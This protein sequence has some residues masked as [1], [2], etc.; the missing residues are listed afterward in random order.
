M[1]EY[2]IS[3]TVLRMRLGKCLDLVEE[4]NVIVIIRRGNVIGRILP[5]SKYLERKMAELSKK[6]LIHWGGKPLTPWNPVTVNNSPHLVSD[7]VC[8]ERRRK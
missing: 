7:L 3:L 5:E 4:G 8:Y 6:G 1:G 2:E